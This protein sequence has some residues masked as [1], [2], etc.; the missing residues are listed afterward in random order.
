[1]AILQDDIEKVV[2]LLSRT[3]PTTEYD[4]KIKLR[5]LGVRDARARIAVNE[6]H[7]QG[8]IRWLAF[9]GWIRGRRP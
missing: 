4:L 8:R 6:A 7:H 5:G 9:E 2:S 3:Y 1:M